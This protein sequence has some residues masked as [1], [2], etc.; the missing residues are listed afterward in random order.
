MNNDNGRKLLLVEDEMIIALACKKNL[1]EF[2]YKVLLAE[3]GESA[4]ALCLGGNGIELVLMD[5]NLG[6]GIDGPETAIRILK[7]ADLPVVFLSGHAEQEVVVKTESVTSYGYVV[8]NSSITV[9]DASIK[10]AYRLFEA[11]RNLLEINARQKEMISKKFDDRKKVEGEM[12]EANDRLRV[13]SVAI[14]QSP[15]TTVITDFEGLIEYVNPKFTDITGYS[16]EEAIGNNPR[17]LK[18]PEKAS[19]EYKELWD[20]ILSGRNWHGVFHNKKKNGD[21]YWESAVISPVK[22]QDG[23]IAHFLA[24][25]EDITDRKIAE[26]RIQ[27]LLSE[28]EL[29]LREVHHRIKN[30]MNT[31]YGLLLLQAHTLKD[32]VSIHALEDAAN[33][34]HSMMLLYTK[35]YQAADFS[36]L[37][38]SQYLPSLIDE[39]IRNFPNN[40]SVRIET[41][42]DDIVLHVQ[43]LQPLGIIINELLTNIMKYAFAG[44][45]DGL[46]TLSA[47]LRENHVTIELADNGNGMPESVSFA[48][49]TGFGLV[50]VSGLIKQIEGTIR[51]E[52]EKGTRIIME[53]E[54]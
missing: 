52:R 54:R 6:P 11:N 10:T 27:N 25:K 3:T 37:S 53:F 22:N 39:I 49:S 45:D 31:I 23:R 48:K 51:I 19:S 50:L 12:Q 32:A 34:V 24:I 29:I 18:N 20:T 17:I 35:L 36:E 21:F 30:N 44:R 7:T 1:E 13:L 47:S 46:I 14:E 16:A 9:L 15:V 5:I 41:K 42:I 28:K 38:V 40:S 26:E 2:G 43:K 8:K 33:R 4:I